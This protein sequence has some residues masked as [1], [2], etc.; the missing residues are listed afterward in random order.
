M[1]ALDRARLRAHPIVREQAD[2]R[3]SW[4]LLGGAIVSVGLVALLPVLQTSSATER[5]GSI[6][7]L[8]QSRA[9]LRASVNSLEA[10]VADLVSIDHVRKVATDRLGMVPPK[11]IL[12]L[13]IAGAAAQQRVPERLLPYTSTTSSIADEPWWRRVADLM[14]R[15]GWLP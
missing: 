14:P 15:P 8:E 13:P 4:R 11:H 6:R 3:L 1:A 7:Q 9:E 2:V 12:Y 10:E 5:G